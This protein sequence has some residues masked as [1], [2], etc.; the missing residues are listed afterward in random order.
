MAVSINELLTAANY[1]EVGKS[2]IKCFSFAFLLSFPHLWIIH[3][4]EKFHELFH[5][6]KKSLYVLYEVYN[7]A[8]PVFQ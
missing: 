6:K 7:E 3:G 8:T 5:I 1:R 4:M 2:I